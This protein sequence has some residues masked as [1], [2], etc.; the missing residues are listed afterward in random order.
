MRRTLRRFEK[1]KWFRLI[2]ISEQLAG[3]FTQ[4]HPFVLAAS[5]GVSLLA[6]AGMALE[7]LLML[8]FLGMHLSPGE[9]MAALTASLVAFL[10]PLPGGL[11][12]L[13]ASQVLVLGALGYPAASAISLA[14]LMRLRDLFNGGLGLVFA[15][16]LFS[17]KKRQPRLIESAIINR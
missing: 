17:G 8:S 11:G 7:Y 16:R 12:A 2:A 5:L 6:M 14:L 9:A 1:R 13:E 4:R 15:A 10:L 3:S